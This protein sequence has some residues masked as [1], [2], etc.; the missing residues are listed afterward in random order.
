[1]SY[2]SQIYANVVSQ[3]L[4]S[5]QVI[6]PSDYTGF[7]QQSLLRITD[8]EETQA[9]LSPKIFSVVYSKF[10]NKNQDSSLSRILSV[11]FIDACN[12]N[13]IEP[14]RFID[15]F[16]YEE[17]DIYK[18]VIEYTNTFRNADTKHEITT[19]VSNRNSSKYRQ[20][21]ADN[22]GD[23][24]NEEQELSV[25]SVVISSTDQVI[26]VGSKIDALITSS[27][28]FDSITL[29][30]KF[31]DKFTFTDVI[32]M[33]SGDKFTAS[34]SFFLSNNYTSSN[35][36]VYVDTIIKNSNLT[37][38]KLRSNELEYFSFSIILNEPFVEYN[39]GNAGI[40]GI[41]I[42]KVS[43]PFVIEEPFNSMEPELTV[44]LQSDVVDVENIRLD[45]NI[46]SILID[47]V[48]KTDVL[49]IDNVDNVFITVSSNYSNYIA[50]SSFNVKVVDKKP[51]IVN[52]SIPSYKIEGVYNIPV[53][54]SQPVKVLS[55][56][57]E[58]NYGIVTSDFNQTDY[59]DSVTLELTL[60]LSDQP[61]DDPKSI[62]IEVESMCGETHIL[63]K[64]YTIKPVS[65][66]SLTLTSPQYEV[67]LPVI[68]HNRNFVVNGNINTNPP[69]SLD[70]EYKN[71]RLLF[72]SGNDFTIEDRQDGQYFIINEY[73][74][75]DFYYINGIT[76][77]IRIVNN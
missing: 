69:L 36:F 62:S 35:D 17:L 51:Y 44:S 24:D 2:N 43:I 47:L 64:K 5:G 10:F 46:D 11:A 42:V 28:S 58:E 41:K 39:D 15:S 6:E 61:S 74:L 26:T 48:A 27:F 77:D 59:L 32:P 75:R 73:V 22:S 8:I 9:S 20:I 65:E 50:R 12:F 68:L 52:N 25:D 18:S 14:L 56:T 7:I 55:I 66:L 53:D 21:S 40:C 31:G 45:Y 38:S 19:L 49:F 60:A 54:F 4:K 63:E 33:L 30:D 37:S 71:N 1:M 23:L 34:V 72:K 76:M 57:N 3:G 67:K 13:N 70:M 29:T 16:V